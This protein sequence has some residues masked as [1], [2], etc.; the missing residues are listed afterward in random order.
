MYKEIVYKSKVKVIILLVLNWG[1]VLMCAWSG[2]ILGLIFFGL[3]AIINTYPLLDS[4]KKIIY[5]ETKEYKEQIAKEY[6]K[7]L[8]DLGLFSY[9]E[10]GFSAEK[11]SIRYDIKWS[12]VNA[13][14]AYKDDHFTEDEICLDVFCD[15]EVSF[16]ITE[17]MAG[18]YVFIEKIA[19]Q[20]PNISKD[21]VSKITLPAF[22]TNLT[23]I[24]DRD[25]RTLEEAYIIFYTIK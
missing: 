12:E 14:F 15:N 3:C 19:T 2:Y 18:W 16:K 10:N 7:R 13:I 21:W 9:F 23:L 22:K 25:N 8:I 1:F 6:Q 17:D 20:L 5:F 11:G 24:Y 4:K